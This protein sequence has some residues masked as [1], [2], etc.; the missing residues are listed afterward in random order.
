MMKLTKGIILLVVISMMFFLAGC[1][2]R[3]VAPVEEV[4]PPAQP[5]QEEATMPEA[6]MPKMEEEVAVEPMLTTSSLEEE[7]ATFEQNMIF[8]EFDKF[9]LNPEAR[10]TLAE[11][12]SFLNS[13][14]EIKLRIE[15]YCDER[16]TLEY[17]LALGERR[18]KSAQEYLVFLGINPDRISIIS[19]GE[20]RPM[21]PNHNEDAWA[22]NRRAQFDILGK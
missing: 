8:F 15:G 1:A 3:G 19:Y 21:D 5:T 18:A 2:K 20:E 4:T 10:K 13:N 14:P 16:G 12:A 11:Q 6:E 9:S 7:M 22:K 17:N